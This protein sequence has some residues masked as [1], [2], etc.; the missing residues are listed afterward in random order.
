MAVG[1]D[2]GVL[3]AV[4]PF[5]CCWPH[6]RPQAISFAAGQAAFTLVVLVLFNLIEPGGWKVGSCA[7]EDVA[8]GAG[9]SLLTGILLWPRGTTAMLRR[10]IGAA[11]ESAA[12]SLDATIS[13]LLGDGAPEAGGSGHRRGLHLG[14]AAGHGG[15]GL[16]RQPRGPAG[17]ACTT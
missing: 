4:L 7:L 1:A 12:G 14:A 15:A 2:Q 8:V 16:P 5:A 11:Y 9:V 10:S 3:W 17:A 6:M 13:A